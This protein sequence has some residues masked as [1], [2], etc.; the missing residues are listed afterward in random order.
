MVVTFKDFTFSVRTDVRRLQDETVNLNFGSIQYLKEY[1]MSV[2]KELDANN[3]LGK[4][5]L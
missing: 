2:R 4:L 5:R 3:R 1:S